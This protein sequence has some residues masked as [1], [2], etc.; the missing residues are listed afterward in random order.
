MIACTPDFKSSPMSIRAFERSWRLLT[1]VH[2]SPLSAGAAQ[3]GQPASH[4]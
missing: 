3:V 4:L 1:S 2:R